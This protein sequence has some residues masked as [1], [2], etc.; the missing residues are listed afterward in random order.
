[1]TFSYGLGSCKAD[2]QTLLETLQL[3]SELNNRNEI[4]FMRLI[5]NQL[6]RVLHRKVR[7]QKLKS[8]DQ[9]S[10]QV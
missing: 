8:Q 10:Y 6:T 4:I 7:D 1:M 3:Y 2:L 9:Q 5:L